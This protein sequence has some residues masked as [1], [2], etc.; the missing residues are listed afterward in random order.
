MKFSC[1]MS[2]RPEIIEGKVRSSLFPLMEITVGP[3]GKM[4]GLRMEA[5]MLAFV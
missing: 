1:F 4:C 5:V 3:T 2:F